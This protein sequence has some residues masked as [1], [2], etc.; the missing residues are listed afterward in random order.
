MEPA[1]II[2]EISFHF[3]ETEAREGIHVYLIS[4]TQTA[5]KTLGEV[6]F[7]LIMFEFR[8]KFR[9]REYHASLP[10]PPS[11]PLLSIPIFSLIWKKD[12]IFPFPTIII[13]SSL[14]PHPPL[15]TRRSTSSQSKEDRKVSFERVQWKIFSPPI[16]RITIK[17]ATRLATTLQLQLKK[18]KNISIRVKYQLRKIIY[19]KWRKQTTSS[20]RRRDEI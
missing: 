16:S 14:S 18:E 10:L 19:N 8:G 17:I 5:T 20:F 13:T 7:P 11:P 1:G 6:N 4:E 12:S 2:A 15:S 9:P 3:L